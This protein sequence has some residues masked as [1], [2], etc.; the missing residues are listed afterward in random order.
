[1]DTNDRI[2][3]L[4]RHIGE[5]TDKFE[6]EA[7]QIQQLKTRRKVSEW[8]LVV[9][10]QFVGIS[11]GQISGELTPISP[12]LGVA[13]ALLFMRGNHIRLALWLGQ[14]I[15][16]LNLG[17]PIIH[18][19]SLGLLGTF[20]AICIVRFTKRWIGPAISFNQPNTV[21]KFSVI[22]LV[23][24]ALIYLP[25]TH[26]QLNWSNFFWRNFASAWAFFTLKDSLGVLCFGSF[27]LIWEHAIVQK[28]TKK[29]IASWL[30]LYGLL[31]LLM[32]GSAFTEDV[33]GY[34]F[35][36]LVTLPTALLI[37]ICFKPLGASF[38]L[39]IIQSLTLWQSMNPFGFFANNLSTTA[40]IV[41]QGKL[42]L[43][44]FLVLLLAALIQDLVLERRGLKV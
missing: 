3:L 42:L 29:Q 25:A 37:A 9:L 24:C 41:L 26:L 13:V 8:V 44:A 33:V 6:A 30:P 10:I 43:E 21:L 32:I 27:Y 34:S 35:Y 1:M 18:S 11:L 15:G 12:N 7:A 22:T 14:T 38:A 40:M 5:L 36:A 31:C 17:F 39:L 16:Y 2:A 20:A 28:P 19:L 4:T 23:T